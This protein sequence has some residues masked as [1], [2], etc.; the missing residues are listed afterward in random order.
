MF[1]DLFLY[2]NNLLAD[3]LS[4]HFVRVVARGKQHN[5]E[6]RD[7]VMIIEVYLI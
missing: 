2:Q 4:G 6:F 1:V 3:N 7:A 5:F